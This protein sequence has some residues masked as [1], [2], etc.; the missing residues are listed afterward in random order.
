MAKASFLA[1]K[2]ECA[3]CSEKYKEPKV[4]P[5]LH[6][7]CKK[8]LEGLLM[9]QGVV[10]RI[11]CPSC[12]ISV[13]IPEGEVDSLPVN[14]FLNNLL[15]L[16]SLHGD[17]GSSNLECDNCESGD[18]P[19]NRCATCCH[20]LCEICTAAHK[21]GR[22]TK[23]HRLMSLEEAKEEGPV[24]VIRP[25]LCKEHEGEILKLFC[26]TCDEA[27]CRDCAIVKHREHK[28][29]F[30][31]DAFSKG[32][33]S[34]LKILSETKTK[35]SVLKEALD[36]VAEVK[37]SVQSHAEQTA[38]EVFNCFQELT[39]CLNTRCN[40]LI[41][42]VEELKK[43]KLKPLEIL[44]GELE[45]ALGSVQSSIEF[46]E[47]A[48]ELGSEVDILN[49]CK[50]MSCR[51]QEL[52]S[53]KWQLEPSAHGGFKFLPDYQL[54]RALPSFGDVTDVCTH[55]ASSTVTMGHGSEGVMYNTLNGQLI[56]FLI[57]ANDWKGSKRKEGGDVFEVEI[58]TEEG[59]IVFNK[60]A[61]DC[62]NGTYSFCF[63]P[64]H[65]NKKHQLSV[66]LD[67]CD[68]KGSPFTW[69]NEMWNLCS[70]VVDD[71][72][73][74]SHYIELTLKRTR[75]TYCHTRAQFEDQNSR[76]TMLSPPPT[77]DGCTVFG[78]SSFG[79]GK[80]SWKVCISG[81][82]SAGLV[83]GVGVS[84]Q[85]QCPCEF[86]WTWT[87]S[88]RKLLRKN[89]GVFELYLDC[90]N[91]TLMI[92]N[93]RTKQ[94]ERMR[95]VQGEVRPMFKMSSIGDE[96]S[97]PCLDKKNEDGTCQDK[98]NEDGTC[99]DKKNEGGTMSWLRS[100]KLW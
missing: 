48:L 100:L 88:R 98:K 32:K 75:A 20:F 55:A 13:E 57:T 83:L 84:P 29:T 69:V 60:R 71:L 58:S 95:G 52:N 31:K 24:A 50:Q 28:Y 62:G 9:K 23:T 44:Q 12:R 35:A 90:D 92:Y 97:L 73:E 38:R 66:K 81:N 96:V 2:L 42:S 36:G 93:Q 16:V 85:K 1:Q 77:G 89:S 4:L 72:R 22:S 61:K 94:L 63:T 53:A 45:T 76:R 91:H 43:A 41:C 33:E 27:I 14:F 7:Y 6:S 17:S 40:E 80:H 18:P 46:T 51:S 56:E 37:R 64:I 67:G 10:W 11:N 54:Q 30:V 5:C 3:V 8:C 74:K 15:S 68:V 21:R 26:E 19:V 47:R 25:S 59:E 65:E 99:Q 39:A 78:S 79:F 70:E 34:V 87:S 86:R 82:F 49:M